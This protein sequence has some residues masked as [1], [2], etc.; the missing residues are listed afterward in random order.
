MRI[1]PFVLAFTL[2]QTAPTPSP[3]AAR[4]IATRKNGG[5]SPDCQAK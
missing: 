3:P 4:E 5:A 2:A 1:L